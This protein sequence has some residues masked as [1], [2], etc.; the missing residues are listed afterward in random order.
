MRI[1]VILTGGTIL[2]E[3]KSGFFILSDKR[4][5]EILSLIPSEFEVEVFSPYFIHSEQLD[6]EYLTALID[7]VNS[8]LNGG[9]DG[10]IIIHGTDTLQ[11]SAAALSLAFGSSDMPI[12]FASAN[13]VLDDKRSNGKTNLYYAARFIEQNIGGVFVSYKNT[14]ERPAIYLGNTLLPH[15]PYSDS[16]YSTCGEYGYYKDDKFINLIDELNL[17]AVG[18][19]SLSKKSP[20]LWIKAYAGMSLPYVDDYRA[21]LVE[22]Y[23]SG[24]LP[25]E[26][27]SFI[28]FCKNCAKPIYVVGVPEGTRYSSA[29][30]FDDL[31]LKIMPP[32]SP[33]FAYILLWQ[34]YSI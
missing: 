30:N 6:G 7:E 25:T 18:K 9:Y 2:S 5:S 31:G 10:I 33:V 28:S 8:K 34:K 13:Y 26:S 15:L 29:I 16:L 14:A 17:D 32:I 24:T 19:Y 20:V 1:A 22:T 23:H 4:K 21:V 27:E 12:V 11:F 3:G